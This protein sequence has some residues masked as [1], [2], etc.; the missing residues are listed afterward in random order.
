MSEGT[1]YVKMLALRSS[2]DY[3]VFLVSRQAVLDI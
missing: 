2:I 1:R 3:E